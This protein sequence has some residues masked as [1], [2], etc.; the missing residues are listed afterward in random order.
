MD[1]G[2]SHGHTSTHTNTGHLCEHGG[3]D[4]T[5]ALNGS[6]PVK[7]ATNFYR[8]LAQPEMEGSLR[9]P[10]AISPDCDTPE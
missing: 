6:P 4:T 10:C 8:V 2:H 9:W 3:L 1:N 7:C 5:T